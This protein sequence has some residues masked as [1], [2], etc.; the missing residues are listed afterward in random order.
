MSRRLRRA[1]GAEQTPL[2]SL[3]RQIHDWEAGKHFPRDWA[4]AYA[5]A[6][7]LDE[8]ELFASRSAALPSDTR[9]IDSVPILISLKDEVIGLATWVEQTNVGDMTIG[10][11]ADVTRRLAVDYLEKPPVPILREATTLYR[12]VSALLRDGRQHLRQTRDLYIIAGQLL[13][14]VSWASSDLGQTGAAEAYARTGW[15]LAEQA[16]HNGLRALVLIA[17]SKNAFWERRYHDAAEYAR[18]GHEYAPA[19]EARVLLACQEADAWQAL[20][21]LGRAREAMGRAEA[22]REVINGRTDPGG[23]WECGLGRQANYAIGVSLRAGDPAEALALAELAR[24]AYTT[25]RR[26]YGTWAQICI[27]AGIARVMTGEPEAA[28]RELMPIFALPA[29]QR[30]AT[31]TARLGEVD[32]R[33]RERRYS[34]D[35]P[36]RAL[37]E[38]I[39]DYRASAITSRALTTGAE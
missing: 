13:A 27:G 15:V 22:A 8:S 29:N 34:R 32:E 2:S 5:M 12:R 28:A 16:D 23:I 30:L 20:G 3:T 19:T 25:E 10:H 4:T 21:D 38:Q 37:Q 14:F 35:F 26:P 1:I 9:E 18:R 33:L 24:E 6:F 31:V 36:A 17:Q 7:R 11:L 39:A